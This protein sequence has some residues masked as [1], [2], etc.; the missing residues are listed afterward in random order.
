MFRCLPDGDTKRASL[1]IP[2]WMFDRGEC[3]AML[4]A[5]TLRVNVDRIL[6]V[7]RPTGHIVAGS[8]AWWPTSV[9]VRWLSYIVPGTDHSSATP[10]RPWMHGA[11]VTQNTG[12]ETGP[13]G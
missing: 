5:Q 1:E 6:A 8:N 11:K 2:E 3:S 9:W 4:M 12:P 10:L 7:R 13:V